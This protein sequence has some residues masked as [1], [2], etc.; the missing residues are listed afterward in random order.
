[1][2]DAGRPLRAILKEKFDIKLLC[3]AIEQFTFIQS[4]VADHTNIF[5]GI[6][7]PDW[8]VE[9]LPKMYK[10]LLSQKDLLK[11][12][13]LSEIEINKLEALFPIVLNLCKKL[14]MS[15][16]KQTIVQCDFH[17]NNILIKDDS[18]NITIIDLGEIVISHPFFSLT[19]CLRQI[20]KHYGLTEKDDAY[21]KIINSFFKNYMVFESK[22]YLLNMLTTANTLWFIYEILVQYR[23]LIAC[24][25]EKIMSFQ[26]GKLSNSLKEFMNL[27]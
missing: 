26:K 25:I 2:K 24:G 12:D 16:I 21:H 18:Q 20:K 23:L 1:M 4:A 3:K 19:G 17:D 9:K 11:E 22:K 14:S 6:G 10:E 13:R 27:Y 7:V 5:L 15:S 8:R